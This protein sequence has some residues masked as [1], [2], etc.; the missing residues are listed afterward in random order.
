MFPDGGTD[1][2]PVPTLTP[3]S[4]YKQDHGCKWEGGEGLRDSFG[5]MVLVDYQWKDVLIATGKGTAWMWNQRLIKPRNLRVERTRGGHLDSMHLCIFDSISKQE[6]RTQPLISSW[7]LCAQA[8][9]PLP[10]APS[11]P[12]SSC[13]KT[14]IFPS[15]QTPALGMLRSVPITLSRVAFGNGHN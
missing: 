13:H 7:V 14:A 1:R 4:R 8:F 3:P 12:S 15:F 6:H 5:K 10:H 11:F 9:S 2:G